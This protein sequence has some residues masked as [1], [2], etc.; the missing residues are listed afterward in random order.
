[1]IIKILQPNYYFENHVF[2]YIDIDKFTVKD[3]LRLANNKVR[4]NSSGVYQTI[5][6]E[7]YIKSKEYLIDYFKENNI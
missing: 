2:D 7:D 5:T 1:M 4:A 3:L 6:S